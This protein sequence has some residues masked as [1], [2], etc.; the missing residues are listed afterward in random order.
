M[1]K[2]LFGDWHYEPRD[3]ANKIVKQ[4]LKEDFITIK[5]TE[6]GIQFLVKNF[7]GDKQKVSFFDMPGLYAIYKGKKCLYV[8]MTNHSVYNRVY[9]FQKELKGKSRDDEGHPGAVKAR[10]DGLTTLNNAKIKFIPMEYVNAIIEDVCKKDPLYER[11][12]D[13]PIDEYIASL[14]KSKYN[15]RKVYA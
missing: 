12:V 10:E 6:K 13:F 5:E 7:F 11:Y 2:D 3:V 14:V 1:Y 15:T 8:G 4:G 9:R